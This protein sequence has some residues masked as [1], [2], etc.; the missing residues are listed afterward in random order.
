MKNS[1][2]KLIVLMLVPANSVA[3]PYAL[4][5]EELV[6]PLVKAVQE[7]SK[8]IDSLTIHQKMTDSLQ[9]EKINSLQGHLT[10]FI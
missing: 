9:N 7:L 2:K 10:T 1:Y 6:V 8:T 4:A 3:T 5:Y